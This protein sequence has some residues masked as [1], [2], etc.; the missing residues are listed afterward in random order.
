M[1]EAVQ[2]LPEEARPALERALHNLD[3]AKKSVTQAFSQALELAGEPGR[4]DGRLQGP[5]GVTLPVEIEPSLEDVARVLG[6]SEDA[7]TERLSQG[8][9]LVQI[10]Q[11]VGLTEEALVEGVLAGVRQRLDI[12]VEE[13][14]LN[15][16]DVDRIIDEMRQEAVNHLYEVFSD[17]ELGPPGIPFSIDDLALILGLEPPGLLAGLHEGRSLLLIA[18]EQGLSKN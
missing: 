17:E 7:L 16:A 10:A 9:T 15:S 8:L 2:F 18:Q 1:N 12:L 11:E 13:G 5:P 3:E 6:I 4:R 14:R